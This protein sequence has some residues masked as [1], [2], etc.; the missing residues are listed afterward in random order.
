MPQSVCHSPVAEGTRAPRRTPAVRAHT[1]SRRVRGTR[2]RLIALAAMAFAAAAAPAGAAAAGGFVQLPG[3]EGCLLGPGAEGNGPRAQCGR[4][5]GLIGPNAVAISP[6]GANVY[7]TA[8]HEGDRVAQRFGGLVVLKR[9]PTTGNVTES[10]CLTSDGTNGIDGQT[11]QCKPKPSLLYA[12]GVTVSPDGKTVFVT[13]A[14]SAS[15]VAFSRDPATGALTRLGCFQQMPPPGSPCTPADL[16]PGSRAIA[17]SAG[18]D[19]LYVAS[20]TEGALSTLLASQPAVHGDGTPASGTGG[21]VA[22]IFLGERV[23]GLANPCVSINGSDGTCAFG[24]AMAGIDA[25]AL[26]PDGNQLYGA[27][28]ESG[29]VDVFSH[30]SAG[31]LTETSCAK[32]DAPTGLCVAAAD[33]DQ[34]RALALSPDGR[35]VYAADNHDGDGQIDILTRDPTTGDLAETGCVQFAEKPTKPEPEEAGPENEA[36]GAA[37]SSG[38]ASAPGLD[39]VQALAVSAD[40]STVYAVG[41][42]S[43]AVFA[44]DSATGALTETSCAAEEDPRCGSFPSIGE[45]TAAAFSADRSQLYVASSTYNA[46]YVLSAGPAVTTAA[47]TTSRA[48]TAR[49]RVACPRTLVRRCRGRVVLARTRLVRRRAHSARRG[50]AQPRLV[51][52]SVFA[53]ASRP[54][55]IG[56]GRSALVTVRLS[57]AASRLLAGRRRV[58]LLASVTTAPR[59]NRRAT[60]RRVLFR[61]GQ[62]RA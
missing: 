62:R 37:A 24:T 11:G 33:L 15:V 36:Q 43:A 32:A 60:A 4:G 7:V 28:P 14:A 21:G 38:C 12:D 22:S 6:D 47:A 27:S 57:A 41:S 45:A 53:G 42:R 54:F 1:A 35:S 13:A 39:T 46:L 29:A 16:F 31:A 23:G 19:A 52:T 44:R 18:G 40:S 26:S 25:L 2:A 30:D 9:D 48:T 58:R 20:P 55:T 50:R 10:E 17:V 61:L 49:V 8:G 5:A 51:M 56:P 34:P 3:A 59:G